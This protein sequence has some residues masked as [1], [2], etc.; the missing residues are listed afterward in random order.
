[1][2]HISVSVLSALLKQ[3]DSRLETGV[4]AVYELEPTLIAAI[5]DKMKLEQG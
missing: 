3:R 4:R 2:R 1:M 5:T